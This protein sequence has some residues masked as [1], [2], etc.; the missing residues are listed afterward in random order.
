MSNSERSRLRTE[1]HCFRNKWQASLLSVS[2]SPFYCSSL[3]SSFLPPLPPTFF[4]NFCC[5]TVAEINA[6]EQTAWRK[7]P[8]PLLTHF[9]LSLFCENNWTPSGDII[10]FPGRFLYTQFFLA[11]YRVSSRDP[12]SFSVRAMYGR[13]T[14][15]FRWRLDHTPLP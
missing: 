11:V 13:V 14:S 7:C 10:N 6:V 1:R 8:A 2:V 15:Q 9:F 3:P 5:A 12:S 4:S